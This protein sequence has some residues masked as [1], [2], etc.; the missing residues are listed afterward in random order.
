MKRLSL[1]LIL[2]SLLV[3][4]QKDYDNFKTP[5]KLLPPETAVV[6]Q[7]NE[8]NDFINSIENHEILSSIYNKEV[9][10]STKLLK[11][12]N[13]TQPLYLSFLDESY[14]DYLLLAEND[15]TLFVIDSLPNHISETLS[16]HKIKKT[17]I[18]SS[19]FYHKVIGN[20]FVASNNLEILKSLK[21]N[22]P[23]NKQ[24]DKLLG[25]TEGKSIASIVFKN[26]EPNYS[27]FLFSEINQDSAANYT[28]V[29]LNPSNN[30][31]V[32]N[33]I[34][35]SYDSIVSKIDCFKNTI[36]QKTNSLSFAPQSTS[37]LLS[38]TFD[39]FATF[40]NNLKELKKRDSD[41]ITNFL[42]FTNEIALI[43]NTL[44][45]HSLDSDLVLESIEEKSFIETFRDVDIYEFGT[46]EFFQYRL[47]PFIQFNNA[48]Y[49]SIYDEFIVFSNSTE[50]IKSVISDAQNN[51]TMANSP[52]FESISN[53]LSDEASFFI[54]KNSESLSEIIGQNVNSY[55]ANVVQF[56]YE[57]NYA[58]INGIIQKSRKKAVSNSITEAFTIT[59][60]NDILSAPQTVKNHVTKAHDI[61]VQDIDNVLYLISSS[62]NILWKKQLQD[63]II[64]KIAQMDMYKNGRLQLVFA[65][66]NQLYVL[67]RN[68]NDVSPFPLKFNDDITQPLSVFDYDN[69]KNYRLLV[70][71]GKDLLMLDA[72]GKT[73]KGF[74]YTDKDSKI[75][76]QPKHFRI[77]SK[78]YIVF[79]TDENLKI[80]NRQ[81][82]I[83]INVKD[84]IRFSG[85]SIYLYKNKFT[86]SNALGQLVQV[87]TKGKINT[88]NLNLK[89]K[90]HIETT[91]K[92]LV[93]MDENK[94]NIKSRTVDMDY[95]NYTAPK[96]FYINDKIYVTTTDLQSKKVFLFDSQAKPIP[97]FPVFGTSEAELQKLDND[98]GLELITQADSKTIVVYKLY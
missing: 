93:L 90:H 94:L 83:R 12:L 79:A 17:Q 14:S 26:E 92:T 45:L 72:K 22:K 76:S 53:N 11:N 84:K 35:T 2:L 43:D 54:F 96:I 24:I 28:I 77:G 1:L 75:T 10:A 3:A 21:A 57:D 16:E 23:T 36:P 91:S 61:V 49:F 18:D 44:V 78:D 82:K 97:N 59:I 69:R 73:V 58:H 8:L 39:D 29:D 30:G 88:Q 51:N 71:Q 67:D 46:P 68:G 31:I 37:S 66:A 64:G 25:A 60:D 33:G 89:D 41:S 50:T 86:T 48:N 98:K 63:K 4:C 74:S 81:G 15:S 13:T 20:I 65:T 19:T 95:G 70:T 85:N 55:N 42:N 6:I 27:K 62:G 56:I 52:A 80:L 87:D 34:I 9:K 47:Q 5:Y 32:Y 40:Y 7:I 38:V